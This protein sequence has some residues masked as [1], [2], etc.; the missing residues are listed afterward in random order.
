D[1]AVE[2][3]RLEVALLLLALM[4]PVALDVVELVEA[5]DAAARRADLSAVAG[6]EAELRE[7]AEIHAAVGRNATGRD[8]ASDRGA[9]RV[10]TGIRGV[11]AALGGIT[12]I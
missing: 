6:R 8:P 11:H 2:V 9:R 1:E 7:V 4:H 3:V 10:V 5:A 12:A